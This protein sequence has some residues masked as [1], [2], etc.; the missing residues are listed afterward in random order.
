ME[1]ETKNEM[2]RTLYLGIDPTHYKTE[3]KIVH[4]PLIKIIKREPDSKELQKIFDQIPQYTHIIF[5][6]KSSVR[7]FLSDLKSR[8]H[9]LDELAYKHIIAVGHVT[10]YYL[11]TEG[12]VPSY[13]S[14]DETEEGVVRLLAHMDLKE[15]FVLLPK[16]A[17]PRAH[18]IHF[19]VEHEVRHKI[20][21]LYDT[22]EEIPREPIDLEDVDEVV[23]TNPLTVE[24]FFSIYPIIPSSIKLHPLG[25]ITR[26]ALR[27]KLKELEPV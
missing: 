4:M 6:S 9:A 22:V 21:I 23:F 12:L 13:I 10:A 5:T 18:L 8:G 15:A 11:K 7:I 16:S 17:H 1:S 26:E 24:T 19:L 2:R 25:N 3:N 20:C 14:A 27:N